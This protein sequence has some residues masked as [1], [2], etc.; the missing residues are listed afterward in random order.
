MTTRSK[1]ATQ[2]VVDLS[3]EFRGT[4]GEELRTVV[5]GQAVPTAR[6]RAAAE[7]AALFQDEH[8]P[9]RGTKLAGGGQSRDT[10]PD[11]ENVAVTGK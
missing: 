6:G 7:A 1:L 9:T 2:P 4:C 10:G 8:I 5:H 3:T 11:D